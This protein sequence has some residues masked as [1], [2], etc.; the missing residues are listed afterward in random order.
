MLDP[1]HHPA[2]AAHFLA[3]LLCLERDVEPDQQF[4]SPREDVTLSEHADHQSPKEMAKPVEKEK[5]ATAKAAV[6]P[7]HPES[8]LPQP[9]FF[10]FPNVLL[11]F[12]TKFN[13]MFYSFKLPQPFF[14]YIPQ[15]SSLV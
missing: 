6:S 5:F 7:S 1:L 4:A 8:K 14:F 13:S 2:L 9:F 12:E 10:T 15:R 11:L 3:T